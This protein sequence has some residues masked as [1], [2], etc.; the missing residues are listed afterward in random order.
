[1]PL[2]QR[3]PHGHVKTGV[4]KKGNKKRGLRAR[5]VSLLEDDESSED[6]DDQDEWYLAAVYLLRRPVTFRF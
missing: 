5:A 4:T 6:E 1:M 2:S 3:R